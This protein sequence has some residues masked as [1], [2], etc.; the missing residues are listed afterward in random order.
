[1]MTGT[2]ICYTMG[3]DVTAVVRNRLRKQLLG[4]KDH[5]N[6][7]KYSYDRDGLLTEIPSIRLIRSVF[8]VKN[9]D[10]DKVLDLLE[11]YN[12]KYFVRKVILEKEDCHILEINEEE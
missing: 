9:D 10:K 4:Y 11:R 12:V 7:G 3:S 6:N 5:S 2:L 8:I 1:M